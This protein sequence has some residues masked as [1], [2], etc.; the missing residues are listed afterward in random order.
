MAK[1][2]KVDIITDTKA[3]KDDCYKKM[4]SELSDYNII[5]HNIPDEYFYR[6]KES[7]HASKFFDYYKSRVL[8][9]RKIKL[10]KMKEI[11]FY[12]EQFNPI[13]NGKRKYDSATKIKNESEVFRFIVEKCNAVLDT[14][15]DDN[16]RKKDILNIDTVKRWFG[17]NKRKTPKRWKIFL[18][19]FGLDL[20]VNDEKLEAYSHQA[21]FYKVFGQ[22]DRTRS[23]EEICMIYCKKRG[24]SYVEALAMY[25]DYESRC[26]ENLPSDQIDIKEYES[27]K[28]DTQFL[29]GNNF[30]DVISKEEL[31]DFLVRNREIL[32]ASN[33]S[34]IDFIQENVEEKWDE[35]TYN[36]YNARYGELKGCLV[37][38][39]KDRRNE[40]KYKFL[41]KVFPPKSVF[42]ASTRDEN[43]KKLLENLE[44]EEVEDID[45]LDEIIGY[46]E[47]FYDL[48]KQHK[49]DQ[50]YVSLRNKMILVH[51]IYYW[52]DY[53]SSVGNTERSVA[54]MEE[55]QE[56]YIQE[57]NMELRKHYLSP[58]YPYNEFDLFIL[59][60]SKT[61]DPIY[62]YY[63]VLNYFY[64]CYFD[65][66]ME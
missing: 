21:L 43:K 34:I 52:H 23:V 40:K 46:K 10:E 25:G 6:D 35:N 11:L 15:P 1:R 27:K 45:I 16:V 26:E 20:P 4:Y 38:D 32:N 2:V 19:S 22:V 66:D 24:M 17:V 37:E 64:H 8:E 13:I 12:N 49:K 53:I 31:I 55:I 54:E 39:E 58:L 29:Y 65:D 9:Y 59:L 33:T 5:R 14:L 36:I 41:D 30:V 44:I 18:I 62:T 63:Y 48:T 28:I 47:D 51:F 42:Y 50:Y 61:A 60:C 56:H 3:F 57:L 7:V